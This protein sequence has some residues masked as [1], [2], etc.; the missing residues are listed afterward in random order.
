M[1]PRLFSFELDLSIYRRP[2]DFLLF[3]QL[4]V[5]AAA[6][7]VCRALCFSLYSHVFMVHVIMIAIY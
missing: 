2:G 7:F 1:Y 3:L 4:E 5:S 6:V